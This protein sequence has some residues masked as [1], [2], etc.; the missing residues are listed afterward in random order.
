MVRGPLRLGAVSAKPMHAPDERVLDVE[1][2]FFSL[3]D[4]ISFSPPI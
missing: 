3:I 4:F 1:T 2:G